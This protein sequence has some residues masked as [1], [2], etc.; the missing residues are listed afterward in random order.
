MPITGLRFGADTYPPPREAADIHVLRGQ[1]T[2][3]LR[4]RLWVEQSAEAAW[5]PLSG[6]T[7]D[8]VEF[9]FVPVFKI[10]YDASEPEFRNFGIR[11]NKATG[12]V[13]VENDWIP[14]SSPRNFIVEAQ[15][16][17]NGSGIPPVKI[18]I[19]IIRV[20]VHLSVEQIWLTRAC[21]RSGVQSL[22]AM[23]RKPAINL[24]SAPSSTTARSVIRPMR[25]G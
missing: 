9:L 22:P 8:D 15:V 14:N 24:L 2:D 20:H 4:D 21:C 6:Y 19:A 5:E 10:E 23:R 12:R 17:D 1:S 11:V 25:A 18:E 13:T 3:N 16:T 7:G